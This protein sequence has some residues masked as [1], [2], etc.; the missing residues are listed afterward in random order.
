MEFDNRVYDHWISHGLGNGGVSQEYFTYATG[1]LLRV[2]GILIIF[3]I[4]FALLSI[5]IL[6]QLKKEKLTILL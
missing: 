2:W 5:A 6:S 1:H 4:A 3:V